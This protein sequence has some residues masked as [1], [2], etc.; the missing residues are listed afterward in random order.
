VYITA[1]GS[2]TNIGL[3]INLTGTGVFS[4]PNQADSSLAPA[5]NTTGFSVTLGNGVWHYVNI[6]SSTLATGTFTMPAAP[7]SG[8]IVVISTDPQITSVTFTPNTGQ[9]FPV[10]PP[11]TMLAGTSVSWIYYN[12][13]WHRLY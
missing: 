5:T 7:T 1:S 6:G 13:N 10:A 4:A 8:Q 12:N 3:S 11:T 9:S 2:S